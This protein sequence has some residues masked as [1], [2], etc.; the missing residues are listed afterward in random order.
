MTDTGQGKGDD[1]CPPPKLDMKGIAKRM[2][3]K[4]LREMENYIQDLED[5]QKG[6]W[7]VLQ[8][9]FDI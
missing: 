5:S 1:I 8:T 7:K 6:K 3:K 4:K 2:S 9:G